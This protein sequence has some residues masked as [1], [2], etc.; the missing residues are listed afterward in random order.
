[1]VASFASIFS[2]SVGC[3]FVLVMVS[4]AVY[5]QLIFDKGAKTIKW[6][7]IVFSTYG[8]GITV[9]PYVWDEFSH[10][11]HRITQNGPKCKS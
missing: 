11:R 2:Q 3:H 5:D 6:E 7:K 10:Y 4:F 8:A 9:Y 1:M